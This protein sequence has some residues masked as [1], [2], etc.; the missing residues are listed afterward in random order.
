MES[1]GA[2]VGEIAKKLGLEWGAMSEEQKAPYN[3]QAKDQRE[4]Y[5]RA[6]AEYKK[7]KMSSKAEAE[8]DDEDDE[9]YSDE[10]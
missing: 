7:N 5:E 9:E 1:P 4:V 10:D 3:Q 2:T 8:M 6:M